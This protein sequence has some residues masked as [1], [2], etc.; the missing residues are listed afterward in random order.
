M[1]AIKMN[2]AAAMTLA[3]FS[4]FAAAAFASDAETSATAGPGRYG[5]GTAGATAHYE[6]DYGFA[7]TDSRTGQVNVARGV[8]VGVDEDGI[9]LS[10]SNALAPRYGPAV[11]TNFNMS[12]GADGRVSSSTGRAEA[13]GPATVAVAGGTNTAGRAYSNASAVSQ[14]V[15]RR[16][17][18]QPVV[19]APSY[20]RPG[21]GSPVAAY[22]E[23]RPAT[24]L[25]P[26]A[27][28]R[29]PGRPT[30]IREYGFG[31]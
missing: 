27:Y 19:V 24:G 3:G 20:A 18:S 31:R 25:R 15:V 1:K 7:R 13:D 30:I 22:R 10:L 9:S 17:V 16:E 21:I 14:P 8:A 5:T 11:A 26:L 12:I 2:L 23:V 4:L 29:I 28:Y 6:G